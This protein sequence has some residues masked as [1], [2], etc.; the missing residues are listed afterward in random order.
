MTRNDAAVMAARGGFAAWLREGRLARGMTLEQ[1]ARVTRI[2]H[3]A[4]E[5]LEEARFEELPADVFVRGFIRNYARCVGLD[6]EEAVARYARC[7]VTPAPVA[8]REARELLETMRAL[9][10]DTA[11]QSAPPAPVVLRA[12]HSGMQPAVVPPADL[13]DAGRGR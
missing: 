3:R 5:R 12:R 10:P 7:G 11:A 9:A 13:A 2:Q 4:L 1:V 8:S 6:A